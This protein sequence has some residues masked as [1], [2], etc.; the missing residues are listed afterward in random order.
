MRKIEQQMC[1][2]IAEHRNWTSGNTEV[3]VCSDGWIGVYLH[4]NLIA[5][6]DLPDEDLRPNAPMFEEYPTRTTASRLSALGF[7]VCIRQF[8][9]YIDGIRA[10][11]WSQP[12]PK[13]IPPAK[14][15]NIFEAAL[16]AHV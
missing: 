16:A 6:K 15:I 7:D 1:K 11:D 8:K 5:L 2:A 13:P 10:K 4:D 14:P 3:F 9:P 12:Q